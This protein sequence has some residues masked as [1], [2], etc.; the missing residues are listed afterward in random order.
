MR[1]GKFA[2]LAL[3]GAL[4]L[5]SV[6]VSGC[7]G[8][9]E[10][11][12]REDEGLVVLRRVESEDPKSM[13]PHIAGDVIS[14]R[15]CGMTYECLFQYDY[16]A[17]P[18]ELVPC[19]A[20]EPFHYDASTFTYTF[21]L[22]NDVHFQADRCFHPDAAKTHY[23]AEGEGKQS[24]RAPGRR[25]T[26]HDMVYSFKRFAAQPDTGGYWILADAKITGL[27]AFRNR[28][29][30]LSGEGPTD[31]PDALLRQ[32]I[33]DS[34]V[35][36]LRAPDDETFVVQM[37]QPYPQFVHAITLSYGAAVAREAAE[38]YREDFFRKPV[39][40][41]AFVL[42]RWRSNWEIVWA[43]NPD[44]RKEYF[45]TSTAPED[46][47]YKPFMGK[48]L[49]LADKV[50]FRV[51]RETQSA[52]LSFRDGLTDFSRPDRDQFEA[53]IQAGDLSPKL[54]A[55]GI[56]MERYAEPT[57]SYISFN[58][59]DPVVGTPAGERGRAIRRALALCID[60]DDYIRRYLNGRGQPATQITPPN[61][62][63]HLTDYAS[64]AQRFDPEEGLNIL[65]AAG[66]IVE[67]SGANVLVRDPDTRSQV[68]VS[69]SLRRN[70][71][72]M[73]DYARFL[74]NCG[75]RVGIVVECE[76]MTFAEWL[77]RTDENDGQAFDSGW[78]MD[79]PDAQNMLQLLYGP[80]KPPGVNNSAYVNPEF[81]RI[82][83]EMVPLN[84][85]DPAERERKTALIGQ[86]NAIV[87]HDVP[88]ILR[89]YREDVLLFHEWYVPPKPNY[90]A[91]T[92][93]KFEHADTTM[94]SERST[95][96]TKA[97]PWPVLVIVLALLFPAGLIG[98][99][100]LRQK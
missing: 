19:L 85:K 83:T 94:R 51:I 4:A 11:N 74:R 98:M 27:E 2:T 59:N 48:Q 9:A 90:F 73:R 3:L 22:R 54:G 61:M 41:G 64:P 44:F 39:G 7:G 68:T 96:W 86:L 30:E 45:P 52:W 95:Q 12:A 92:F 34:N 46:E 23:R 62:I 88:W 78:I 65:R 84:E 14:S 77:K 49:P 75:A 53:A 36:G 50:I 76:L 82:Y 20:R 28:A 55:Q 67:G 93:I 80:N 5:Q 15:H 24:E 72:A 33:V 37:T 99:K 13:D 18:P 42:D 38:Y 57:L 97:S 10:G 25:M 1:V 16:L 69:I 6:V 89:D 60:R 8:Q 70:T 43:R 35:P 21:K 81:D 29:L 63:G 100:I 66:F 31:D 79:Y 58:M 87:D 71:D 32:H 56:N 40:T 17:H 47:R 26:A 91:Y